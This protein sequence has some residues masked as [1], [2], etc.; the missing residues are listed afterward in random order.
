MNAGISESFPRTEIQLN[1]NWRFSL[2]DFRHAPQIDF[3]DTGWQTVCLPHTWNN[4]DGQDGGTYYCGPGWYRKRLKIPASCQTRRVFIR[5]GA[6]GFAADVYVNGKPVWRHTGGFAA[7]VFDITPYLNYGGSNVIAVRVDN[8]APDVS[9][10]FRIAPI[11]ADFTMEGGLYREASLIV[12]DPVHISLTDYAS[13]G[14]FIMQ[15]NVSEKLAQ[16]RVTVLVRNDSRT[17]ADLLVRTEIFDRKDS[18]VK[19]AS[20]TVKVDPSVGYKDVQDIVIEAPHLWNGRA[21]PYLYKAVVSIYSKDKL[22]DRVEQPVGLRFYRVDP[23]NGFFLNGK[24][25]SL[26]G[27]ALHEDKKDRGRAI[28]D[29]DRLDEMKDVLD[30]GAT[31]IRMAHYQYGEEMY[32]LCDRYGIVVWTEIPLVNQIDGSKSFAENAAQQL[33]ELIRQNY[34]HPSVL[35]WGIFNE[36]HNAKGPDPRPLVS[37]LNALAKQEDPTRLTTAASDDEDSTNF[38]TDVLGM[39]KYFGWYYGSAGDLG[40][41]LDKWHTEHPGRAIGISEYGAGGSIFQHEE[42][43]PQQPRTDGPWHPEEYQTQFHE[44]S[45]KAIESRPFIW[46][47]TLW[48]MYDFASDY[49]NEGFSPGINDKGIV[50]QGHEIKKDAYFWYKV[51]WNPQPMVHING[52]MFTARDTSAITVEVYSN[53]SAVEL[54]VGGRSL[55]RK[56]SGDRRFF[57]NDVAL[58]PGE[59]FVK[60]VASF[61]GK[62]YFDQCWWRRVR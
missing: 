62:E 57:W 36:I 26:H 21:D 38:V 34:N 48:N 2:G 6:A 52:K 39:N 30:I 17:A 1:E 9:E 45:W 43:L 12:T 51:N 35:F 42:L 19:R 18:A 28:T 40:P 29:A 49:R 47:S 16:L 32:R 4:F 50:T 3:D 23:D 41:F 14:V 10:K 53:A 55:G 20:D 7:F 56:A 15:Q 60:A 8:T 54:F 58:A 25:Y 59:N 27:V 46:F 24:P 31:M 13:P 33:K 5:F 11:S 44:I 37:E 61:D 22:V